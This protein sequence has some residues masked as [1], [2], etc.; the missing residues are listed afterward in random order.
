MSIFKRTWKK[1][2]A[3]VQKRIGGESFA[4]AM[5]KRRKECDEWIKRI[6]GINNKEPFD[7]STPPR[8]IPKCEPRPKPSPQPID[9]LVKLIDEAQAKGEDFDIDELVAKVDGEALKEAQSVIDEMSDDG[10]LLHEVPPNAIE[11]KRIWYGVSS[12]RSKV[13]HVL[14]KLDFA[15]VAWPLCHRVNFGRGLE[16]VD[17]IHNKIPKDKRLCKLCKEVIDDEYAKVEQL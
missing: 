17:K 12:P 11:F 16:N 15:Y 10:K 7:S 5:D 9:K 3:F 2:R 13:Y 8:P 1:L 14:S 4:D 6:T